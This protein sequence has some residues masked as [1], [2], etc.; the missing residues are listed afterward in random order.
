MKLV[1]ELSGVELKI[2]DKVKTFRN[3]IGTIKGMSPPHKPSS[4]G[5]VSVQL[6]GNELT[7]EFFPSVI[8]AKFQA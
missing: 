8:F 7:T 6:E 3:E 5:R 2:G 4:S 1:D